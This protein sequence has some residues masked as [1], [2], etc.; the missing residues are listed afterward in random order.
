MKGHEKNSLE[1]I[2]RSELGKQNIQAKN[3]YLGW[4]S[5]PCVAGLAIASKTP[6]SLP[7]QT[8]ATQA[9]VSVVLDIHWGF[10]WW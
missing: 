1:N 2:T 4:V 10:S 9:R 3:V 8:P 5:V 7:F 6:F